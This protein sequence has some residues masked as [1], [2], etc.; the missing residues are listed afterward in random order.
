MK[1][2]YCLLFVLLILFVTGCN[3][4]ASL[5][6]N[7]SDQTLFVGDKYVIDARVEG[8]DEIIISA[9]LDSEIIIEGL[10]LTFNKEG[11]FNI[12][13]S[14]KNNSE[15]VKEF[16]VTVKTNNNPIIYMEG[17]DKDLSIELGDDFD[18]LSKV[19]AKDAEDGDISNKIKVSEYDLSTE[20]EKEIKFEVTDSDGNK[21]EFIRII[22]VL[23]K[24]ETAPVI[25]LIDGASDVLTIKYGETYD[26]KDLVAYD[27]VDGDLTSSIEIIEGID[28]K[29]YNLQECLVSVSDAHGNKAEFKRKVLVE[30]DYKTMYIGHAGSYYGI[31]NTEEA[32]IN[33]AKTLHYQALECDLKQTSDGVFVMCHDNEFGGKTIASTK[34]SALKDVVASSSRTAGY[35]GKDNYNC[36]P[37]GTGQYT[38]TICSLERYLEICKEYGCIA[39]IELKSS[40]GI[41]NTD[42]SRMAALMKEIE[43][44]DMLHNVIFLGSQYNCLI[45]VKQHGYDYI[46]CQYLVN[47][48]ESQ[49][50]FDRCKQYNL[51]VSTNVTDTY[52]NNDTWLQKYQNAGIKVSTYTFTQYVDYEDVQK[53]IDKGVDYVTCDWHEIEKLT[54][55]KKDEE[56]TKHKVEFYGLNDKLIDTLYV[57]DGYTLEV[58]D[59]PSVNGYKFIGW[60]TT[61]TNITSDLKVKAKYELDTFTITYMPNN[62]KTEEA[63]WASK[64]EFVNEF[65]TDLYNWLDSKVG[66]LS[67]LTKSGNTY[68][69]KNNTSTNGTATWD[70]V[71]SLRNLDIYVFEASISSHIYKQIEGTNSESYIPLADEDYFLN[72]ELYRTKY[73]GMNAYLLNCINKSYTSYSTVFKP[74]SND[75]VQIFFRFHQWCKGTS[76][77]AFDNIPKKYVSVDYPN[78][79]IIMP[80]EPVTYTVND[81]FDLPIPTVTG[82]TFVGWYLNPNGTGS[83]VTKIEKGTIGDRV[84]YACWQFSE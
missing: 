40:A 83:K 37:N 49:T 59:A 33:A 60:D 20:G 28:S 7:V 71:A 5:V 64:E 45:W 4:K 1:K 56:I 65:Y 32:F 27:D 22:T 54:N 23:K 47:S 12:S 68:T 62:K 44:A 79:N 24:D 43:K 66:Q 14:L 78:V 29:R 2:I 53:W 77:P 30:W 16:T 17:E 51:E 19:K 9:P 75:R 26:A 76:I 73:Q 63:T 18:P 61:L 69:L 67:G 74:A 82:A 55:Y 57:R 38:S 13:V 52:S 50:V 39:V 15:D 84:Y 8:E 25:S 58:D 10:S 80:T 41:T 11:V 6:V 81:A 42:Q 48:F 31:A 21:I 36:I 34:W 35:P 46:P 70:S 3:K 72:C